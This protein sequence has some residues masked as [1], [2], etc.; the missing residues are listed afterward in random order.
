MSEPGGVRVGK[1]LPRL[2]KR[3]RAILIP[4]VTTVQTQPVDAIELAQT[5]IHRWDDHNKQ[6]SVNDKHK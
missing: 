1:P 6:A 4:I 2:R 3:Q 5:Y